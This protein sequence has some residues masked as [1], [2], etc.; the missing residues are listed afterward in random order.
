MKMK[1]L[2]KEA[3]IWMFC[4]IVLI[5]SFFIRIPKTD[6]QNFRNA[7]ATY[8]VLLTMR[9]YDETPVSVHKFLPIVSLGDDDDK[10]IPWGATVPDQYG[11]YYYTSFSPAGY[12]APYLFVK[13]FALPIN[14][15]SLYIFNFILYVLC[16]LLT[17]RFFVKVFKEKINRHF[18]IILT[19]LI[20]LFQP[21]IMHSQGMVYWHQSLFQLLFLF[22]LNLFINLNNKRNWILFF[23]LCLIIPYVEWTGHVSNLGFALAFFLNR[24]ISVSKEKITIETKAFLKFITV[25]LLSLLSFGIFVIHFLTTVEIKDFVLALLTRFKSRGILTSASFAN[26]ISGYI[27]SFGILLGIIFAALIVILLVKNLRVKLVALIREYKTVFFVVSF[28]L[29][30]NI[31]LKQHAIS[32]TFDRMKVIFLLVFMVM[33]AVYVFKSVYSRRIV[34]CIAA[35]LLAVMAVVNIYRYTQTN[36]YYRWDVDYLKNNKVIAERIN[37]VYTQEN[38]I[39][40][41]EE[42]MTRGYAN[43]LFGRGIYETVSLE[44]AIEIAADKE[45][46]YVVLFLCKNAPC[47]VYDYEDYVVYDV[48]NSCYVQGGP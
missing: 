7:D 13:L 26:L 11:N 36:G 34:K 31:L 30:E 10:N 41:H 47:N 22:Q 4:I 9:A 39:L 48:K 42:T 38:S 27:E 44:G 24:T 45:K 21:E 37:A 46:Q 18:I 32:Y 19:A 40:A 1:S 2:A 14:E 16:F 12:V 6:I 43:L 35:A 15:M 5:G 25:G 20:Y 17:G 23:L 28:V 8:H 29:L 3:G 33:C